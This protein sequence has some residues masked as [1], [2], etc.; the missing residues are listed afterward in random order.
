MG[1]FGPTPE[2]VEKWV[3]ARKV[4]KLIGALNSDDAIVVR[5]AA[6]GL[7]KVGGSEVL[8]YCK[9]NAANE[10]KDVRWQITKILGL[11]GSPAAMEILG[12]VQDPIDAIGRRVKK[13]QSDNEGL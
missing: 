13:A 10:N 2:K 11:I 7:G 4:K 6:E 5:M 3:Q 9:D 1:L 8:Q 12:T